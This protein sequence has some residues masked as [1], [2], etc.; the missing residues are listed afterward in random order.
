MFL[1]ACLAFSVVLLL[2]LPVGLVVLLLEHVER[3]EAER[4]EGRTPHQHTP[5][6]LSDQ[7]P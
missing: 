1:K 7:G 5:W 2:L 4:S 6:L 3:L